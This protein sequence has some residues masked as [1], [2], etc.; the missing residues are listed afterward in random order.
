MMWE[1]KLYGTSFLS[2]KDSKGNSSK[3]IKVEDAAKVAEVAWNEALDKVK[4]IYA[5]EHDIVQECKDL[6]I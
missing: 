3:Y 6:K 5:N 1:S 2:L 4:E